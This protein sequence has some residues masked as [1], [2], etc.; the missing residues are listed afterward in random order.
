MI[1]SLSVSCPCPAKTVVL[2]VLSLLVSPTWNISS[3]F[4]T[5]LCSLRWRMSLNAISLPNKIL[6][7]QLI[8]TYYTYYAMRGCWLHGM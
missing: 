5:L 3:N 1:F 4:A 8:T 7:G 2:E 6:S